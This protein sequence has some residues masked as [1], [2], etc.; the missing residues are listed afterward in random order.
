MTQYHYNCECDAESLFEECSAN[1]NTIECGIQECSANI[2]SIQ[3]YIEDNASD[4]S[5]LKEDIEKLKIIECDNVNNASDI[6]QLKEDIKKLRF[7]NEMLT[8]KLL[9]LK[10]VYCTIL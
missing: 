4:I 3:C 7:D 6:S 1:I 5:Q 8:H 10:F 2:N 9:Q